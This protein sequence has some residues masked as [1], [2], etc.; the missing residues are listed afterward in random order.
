MVLLTSQ[1]LMRRP[2]YSKVKTADV[3]EIPRSCSIAMESD[4]TPR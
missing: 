1:M 4:T 3:I 2:S